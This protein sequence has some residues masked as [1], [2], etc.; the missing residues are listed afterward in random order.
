M[1]WPCFSIDFYKIK[2]LNPIFIKP[3]EKKPKKYSIKTHVY[4]AYLQV[5]IYNLN[6]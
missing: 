4:C 5:K 1:F 6:I 2:C 3:K